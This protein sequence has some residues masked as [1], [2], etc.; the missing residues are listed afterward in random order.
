MLSFLRAIDHR[1]WPMPSAPWIMRQDWKTLLFAHWPIEAA[2]M[3]RLAPEPLKLDLW[4]GS[5]YV[6]VV[7]FLMTAV[8]PRFVPPLP[9]L[10]QFPELNV[11]TYVTYGG[12]PGVY[13]FSLDA[14][15]RV[16]VESARL[17]FGL[18][19]FKA[20]MSIGVD[21][22]TIRYRSSRTDRR[23]VSAQFVAEYE[24]TGPVYRAVPG[25]LDHWLTE[26]YCL[27]VVANGRVVRA[28][29]HHAPWPLQPATCRFSDNGMAAAAG[30][31]LP[32][33]EPLLH[34]AHHLQV[35]AWAPTVVR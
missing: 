22:P 17:G 9:G 35:V 30:M 16:A 18:P 11:R 26:R 24:P 33:D 4:N 2:V 27:Y 10:S 19:Y 29:V 3:R 20:T 32:S 8:R 28:E 15:N 7:P 21:G 23:G 31:T 14:D 12:K 34:Y 25:S 13:F 1:P 5:A 6:G